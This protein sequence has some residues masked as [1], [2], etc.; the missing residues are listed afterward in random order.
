MTTEQWFEKAITYF[1]GSMSAE[2]A[3]L[4]EMETA[5]SEELSQLMQLWKNTDAEAAI[6]EQNKDAAAAFITT[7][8]KLKA[9]FI[10]DQQAS[11]SSTGAIAVTSGKFSIWKWVAVAAALTGIFLMIRLLVPSP[12]NNIPVAQHKINADSTKHIAVPDTAIILTD[13]NKRKEKSPPQ[14]TQDNVQTAAL[15]AQAF[16]P[17]DAPEDPN[18][19]LDNA[20]FYYASAQYKKAI[21]AIDSA[22]SKSATRGNDAFT[23]LTSFYALYYKALSMML[24]NNTAGAIPV[25]R[26]SV[27][28]SPSDTLKVKAQWYLAL[29]YLK[30]EKISLAITTLQLLINNAAA[31]TYK[32]KAEKLLAALNN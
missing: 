29:A 1:N 10:T 27:L 9:D 31:G 13:E 4:F 19:P 25:L 24:L 6:Y 7:H 11:E 23:P 30:Q 16:V 21:A 8:Q 18:G 14:T 28:Q 17:D 22:D 5:A 2:E 12:K 32:S 26:E 20:F 3:Q 15:Y